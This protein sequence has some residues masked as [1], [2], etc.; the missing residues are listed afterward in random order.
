MITNMLISLSETTHLLSV[1]ENI[2]SLSLYI[3][4]CN[5]STVIDHKDWKSKLALQLLHDAAQDQ[6]PKNCKSI[7]VDILQA[8]S[9]NKVGAGLFHILV[10]LFDRPLLLELRERLQLPPEPT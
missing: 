5:D 8:Y 1:Q 3:W 10:A 9:C 6:L 4:V 2:L 7:S